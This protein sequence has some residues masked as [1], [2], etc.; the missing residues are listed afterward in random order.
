MRGL[1]EGERMALEV[2]VAGGSDEYGGNDGQMI[3]VIR[4]SASE[5]VR[6]MICMLME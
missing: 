5:S 3:G 2:V 1:R 4:C 6:I